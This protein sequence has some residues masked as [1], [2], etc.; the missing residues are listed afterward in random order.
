MA[1]ATNVIPASAGSAPR[2]TLTR[3][4][5]L[6]AF[7]DL[8]GQFDDSKSKVSTTESSF[9]AELR[10][11]GEIASSD[12]FGRSNL[13]AD[14]PLRQVL[15]DK[16]DQ[17][18]KVFLGWEKTIANRETHARFKERTSDSLLVFV[19]G[20]VKA[21]KSSLGNYMA[22]GKTDPGGQHSGSDSGHTPEFFVEKSQGLT[23]DV[24]DE[25]IRR[26]RAFKVGESETTSA[27]QGFRLPGLTWVD[28]PGL[29]SK[30]GENGDLAATY[31]DAADMILYLTN[32]VAPCKRSDMVELRALGR[33]EHNLA[34]V[35]T[36]SDA[37]DEELDERGNLDK[38]RIMKSQ[39]D[40]DAQLKYVRDSLSS[41]L[42]D[43]ASVSARVMDGT[44]RRAQV[45]SV[46]AA[47]AEQHPDAAGMEHSGVGS[48]LFDVAALAKGKGV[49]DKLVRPLKILREFLQRIQ[50]DD[51]VHIQSYLNGVTQSVANAR[52]QADTDARQKLQAIALQ[53]GPEIDRLLVE[54]SKDGVAFKRAVDSAYKQWLG[55]GREAIAEAF[56]ASLGVGLTNSLHDAVGEIPEFKPLTQSIKRKKTVNAKRGGA[57]GGLLGAASFF[58]PGGPLIALAVGVA[59]TAVGGYAGSKI[60]QTLDDTETMD[61]V[62]GDNTQEVGIQVRKMV[63]EKFESNTGSTLASMALV[64]FSDLEQW[65]AD[66]QA[67]KNQ[68]SSATA[69]LLAE[70][71]SHINARTQDS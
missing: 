33:K 22:W 42:E 38:V 32:S 55:A 44:L 54:H 16:V 34:V 41:Q 37:W 36:G 24:S 50:A 53:I 56:A 12:P 67:Q 26:V 51:L 61:V 64:C 3:E 29:H 13:E 47:Y 21:G 30:H 11:C 69:Q 25:S 39:A 66:L 58:V 59:A 60:G 28:S 57:L 18:Q 17:I 8:A 35:I 10:K 1:D 40:R 7:R 43:N 5:F 52:T 45:H 20:K 14:H 27:I 4:A 46:S 6:K 65:M 71:E 48:M 2:A 62:V 49:R 31:V 23:E 68:V 63:R 70:L 15:A 19:Y 9:F